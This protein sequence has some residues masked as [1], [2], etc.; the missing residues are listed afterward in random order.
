MNKEFNIKYGSVEHMTLLGFRDILFANKYNKLD[1]ISL[2][3]LKT[4]VVLKLQAIELK[5]SVNPDQQHD[6]KYSKAMNQPYPRKCV[7]CGKPEQQ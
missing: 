6:C 7:I 2:D 1:L 4:E 3:R 5:R